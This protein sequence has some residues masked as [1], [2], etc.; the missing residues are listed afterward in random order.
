[1]ASR[2]VYLED[3]RQILPPRTQKKEVEV[4]TQAIGCWHHW[5]AIPIR[6]TGAPPLP[7]PAR[8][9]TQLRM[10]LSRAF[11]RLV[12]G[13]LIAPLLPRPPLQPTPLGFR[14]ELHYAYHQ[15]AGHDIDMT[16]DLLSTHDTRFIPPL[17]REIH[18]IEH[19]EGDVF[20]MGWD[21]EAPQ[22]ISLYEDSDFSGYTHGQQVPRPFRLAL[23]EIPRQP[24]VSPVYLQHVPPL[25]PFILFP[26]GYGPA[27]RDV[28]I[29]TQSKRVA[30][31]PSIDRPFSVIA[32]REEIQREDDEILHQLLDIA[33]TP[34][35][36]I[37]F[38]TADRAMCIM[39]VD[40]DLPP[41]G[42]DHVRPLFIDVAYSSR[43]VSS[44]LLDNG[45]TL[46][47][48]PLVTAIA[49]G[50]SPSDFGPST[51]TAKAYDGTQR[52]VMGT[53]TAHVMIWLVKYSVHFQV[54]MI[55]SSFNLLLSPP[56]IHK[57]SAIP[58]SLHQKISHSEDDLH[59]T[60]F[61][62]DEVQVVSLGDDNR[63]MVP[64]S[65][66]QYSST[67][68]L[69]MMRGMSYLFDLGLG[70]RQHGPR[71][72][73]F[74]VDY[75]IPYGLGYTPMKEDA[76]Y[77]LTDYFVRGSNHAP[78]MEGIVCISEVVEVQ[79][80]QRTL[81]HM[82]LGTGI[83]KTPDVMIVAPPSPD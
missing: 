35:G 63:D 11:Q 4:K 61:T 51:Q 5:P 36:L 44:V 29:V 21:R 14:T 31:P 68:V 2:R 53:L 25:T 6:L 78:H 52:T 9:F 18:L 77:M 40:N 28:Q 7:R 70:R 74:I 16:I 67:L 38:M 46:N 41:E 37:H 3:Y 50:F 75:D 57:A 1:M 65:F 12:E 62:F 42:S 49:L 83:L 56:W 59:L 47:V 24:V 22:S 34:K 45:S 19:I 27:H 23:D 76:C 72:F 33:T 48:C 15:R 79:D 71:E 82:H 66:D 10:P 13:G 73:T 69:N 54:L 60:R 20:M 58:S 26:E 39:F 80:L 64:M 81:G 8:Q 55:Q 43:R 30:Y 32:V 17:P